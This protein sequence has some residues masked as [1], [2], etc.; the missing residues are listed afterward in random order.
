MKTKENLILLSISI[1]LLLSFIIVAVIVYQCGGN[2]ILDNS[3]RDF[4]Y[5]IRGQKYGIIYWIFR[6]LTEFG[7]VYFIAILLVATL[8]YSKLDARWFILFIGIL[9]TTLFNRGV[10]ELFSRQRPNEAMWWM[11]ESSNSFP[12]GHSTSSGFM[13]PF[14]AYCAYK[15]DYSKK[16][17]NIL[18]IVCASMLP[19]IMIS[20]L[21]LGMHFFTDVI[22]GAL[23]GAFFSV[24]GMIL[25]NY[26][27][28]NNILSE[29]LLS[30]IGNKGE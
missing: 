16:I 13:Y 30:K 2:L 10:K 5:S 27:I 21:V 22:A 28:K 14:I 3:I 15:S 8:I 20:R 19:I 26:C 9:L 1:L 23:S 29:G 7:D 18:Y 25:L 17:K 24:L 12:S 11:E 6:V 4:F